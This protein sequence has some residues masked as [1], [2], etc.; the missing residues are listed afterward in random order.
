MEWTGPRNSLCRVCRIAT[1]KEQKESAAQD[2][3]R[4]LCV[5]LL[6]YG[7]ALQTLLPPRRL[8][9]CAHQ[10]PAPGPSPHPPLLPLTLSASFLIPHPASLLP[11]PFP[12]LPPASPFA[13]PSSFLTRHPAS[14]FPQSLTLPPSFLNPLPCL[15]LSSPLTLPPSFNLH[16]ASPSLTSSSCGEMQAG[17]PTRHTK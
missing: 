8:T 10:T 1:Q 15:P 5:I 2:I 3:H 7:G 13:L 16:P 14:L 9:S 6:R 11:H 12:C 4:I 17:I